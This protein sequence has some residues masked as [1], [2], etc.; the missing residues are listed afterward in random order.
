MSL[1]VYRNI[2]LPILFIPVSRSAESKGR[3]CCNKMS[4][5]QANGGNQPAD[6][7]SDRGG[8]IPMSSNNNGQANGGNQPV[9][10]SDRS[11]DSS[12]TPEAVQD[13]S[14]DVTDAVKEDESVDKPPT[15]PSSAAQSVSSDSKSSGRQHVTKLR[16]QNICCAM[17]T[18]L[19]M[20]TLEPLNGVSSVSVNVIGRIAYVRYDPDLTS[21]NELANALN[22]VHLG[23]KHH[24]NWIS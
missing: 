5:R 7:P 24:G 9:S 16:V 8:D 15:R 4:S 23:A 13:K 3:S 11:G 1:V 6:S 17:E 14:P 18:K 19:V 2:Q 20:D 21:P 10:P 22:D 12:T